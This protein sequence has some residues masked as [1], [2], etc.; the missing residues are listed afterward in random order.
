MNHKETIK[1][2]GAR[3]HNLKN[4]HL[5]IP[6]NKL[7]VMCGISGSGKSSLAFD[8]I[9]AEG[10]RRYVESLSSYARQFLGIMSKPDVDKIEGLSPAIAIDQK[11]ISQNPRSTVGTITEIYDYLRL[12]FARIGV[13]HCPVCGRPVSRQS[14]TQITDKIIDMA[15]K[16]KSVEQINILAPMM[17]DRKGEHRDILEAIQKAG[18]LRARIDGDV[19][20]TE[21][22]WN[23]HLDKNKTH[24]IEVVV[25]RL[26]EDAMSDRT[27]VADSVETAFKLT[28]GFIIIQ[29]LGK[30]RTVSSSMS[31]KEKLQYDIL[32]S[33]RFACPDCSTNIPELEP[34][35]FS[36][37]SPHG[38][39]PE[40]TGL[41]KKLEVDPELVIP[42]KRL[43]IAEGAVKPWAFASHKMGRQGFFFSKLEQLADS[44]GFSVNEPIKGLPKS[45]LDIILYGDP[46]GTFEGVAP[47]LERRWKETE[48]DWSR[49]E[50]EQYMRVK[51]CPLCLGKRLKKEAL[52]VRV[53]GFSIDDVVSFDIASLKDL[54][55]KIAENKYEKTL[56]VHDQR[57]A[58]PVV[59]EIVER[60]NFLVS[61]GLDYLT[62][63][64]EA[65]TLA[66]GEA[67]RIRLATQIGSRLVGVT[68]ILD[69][70]SIGLHPRD[71]GRLIDILKQLRDLGNSV[72]VVE[73]DRD[74]IENA[75]W[76]VDVGPGA[77]KDG[78]EITF[79]GTPAALMRSSALTGEY[80]SGRIT[81]DGVDI[82]AQISRTTVVPET[83]GKKEKNEFL[84]IKG[85]TEHNLKNV[86]VKIPLSKL[87]CVTGVSGSGKS[88]LINT[89][90]SRA[91]LKKFYHAKDDPGAHKAIIGTEH[92][93]KVVCIDQ[94]PIGR[95]PRS[96]P[97]T[98]TGAFSFIRD[99][100]TATK[101]AR[102]RGYKPGRFSFN[103]KGGRCESCEGQ[104]LKRIEM[105]FLPDVYV[106]C[107][108]CHGT[109][110]N[111]EVLEI[112]YKGKNIAQVLDMSIAESAAF[113]ENVSG[114]SDKLR[115]LKEVG[116]SYMKLGQPATT[117][118]GGE[119]QRVKLATELSRKATGK[120]LYIL[121]EPTTGL[122]FDDIKKLLFVLLKLV[123]LGN[124]VVV[125]EHNLDVIKCADWIID[126]G[127][128]GGLNGG[129]VVAEGA[130]RDV[131]K[132]KDSYTGSFLKKYQ[133]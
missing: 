104:G 44:F 35:L 116:L 63:K 18:Y 70:P 3:V 128:G 19:Y 119:A 105:H 37:N 95:T 27:R 47:Y 89:I 81:I 69:E 8:T 108:E 88:T 74:T 9:Y 129:L 106:E 127:P 23:V 59:R 22:I 77:G 123:R 41:G 68:Y 52:A 29:P 107:Q 6:R 112:E 24:S 132:N 71:Q 13:P 53:L 85:A 39:C 97:A 15:K 11:N 28:D 2:T 64:R 67:Q 50:I 38:A 100:F 126:L 115:T 79:S 43:S 1:I 7:V 12:L 49:Q 82:R 36:F 73:H 4:I 114:L 120:T 66:G 5:E 80:L 87:V 60:L 124:S 34:R 130:P 56:S 20:K 25:D 30:K 46:G 93:N 62:L 110:Y 33:D 117:L 99:I 72:L 16:D 58:H 10:Q 121:D 65:P 48:S 55:G 26:I 90:L 51:V 42:N 102:M 14:V 113:F 83:K 109:R 94:S 61:V 111:K 21:D 75:D 31:K 103:M 125:I 133:K 118:S 92:I 86:D 17:R 131:V 54:F 98:Y 91:L 101:E 45:A 78:G 76:V 57:I 40:C 84:V 122:H 32:F 96:N